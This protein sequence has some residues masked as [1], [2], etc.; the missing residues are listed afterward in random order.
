MLIIFD[1]DDTLID[2]SGCITPVK[3]AEALEVMIK[4]GLKVGSKEKALQM[5]LEIDKNSP[6][7]RETVR[8]FLEL[9]DAE[10]Y[11]FEIGSQEYYGKIKSEVAVS[12]KKGVLEALHSL[13]TQHRLVLVTIGIPEQQEIKLKWAGIDA[14]FFDKIMV[15]PVWNK[16]ECYQKLNAELGFVYSQFLVCGDSWERDLQPAK[17]LGCKTV[18]LKSGRALGA[19]NRAN[20]DFAII[21]FKEILDVVDKLNL[22]G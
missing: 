1:L 22:N 15:T 9:V 8:R 5:M 14:A 6:S 11:F 12:A 18:W 4:A 20:P 2:T 19:N 10:D 7:G 16:K 13:K 17:E 21:N 3:M